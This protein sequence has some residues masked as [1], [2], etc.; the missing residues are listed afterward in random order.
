MRVAALK[1]LRELYM[2]RIEISFKF[3][4]GVGLK[5]LREFLTSKDD[6]CNYKNLHY[7]YFCRRYRRTLCSR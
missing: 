6:D 3:C 7:N 4:E 5:Y 2:S 1:C